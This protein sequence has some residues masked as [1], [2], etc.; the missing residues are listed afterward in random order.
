MDEEKEIRELIQRVMEAV[1]GSA[2]AQRILKE[3]AE[4]PKPK[5]AKKPD[6]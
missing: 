3:H 2:Y 1:T 6:G 5:K 4:K